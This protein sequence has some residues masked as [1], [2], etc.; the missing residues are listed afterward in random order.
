MTLAYFSP[1]TPSKQKYRSA[2]LWFNIE[3]NKLTPSRL[4]T[5][6]KA[7]QRG[8]TQHEIFFGEQAT[9]WNPND[10]V[11][12][13]VNC[14]EDAENTIPNIEYALFV[15]FEL[16]EEISEQLDIDVYESITTRI[17]E[18]VPITPNLPH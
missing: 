3:N 17:R 1:T 6:Y 12:V 13:R 16:A 8:T 2:H 10:F 11:N 18:L 4:N 14:R 7:V 5:D 15:T 9:A